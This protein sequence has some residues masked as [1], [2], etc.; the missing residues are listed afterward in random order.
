MVNW[1]SPEEAETWWAE[2]QE[3][4]KKVSSIEERLVSI[5]RDVHRSI[6]LTFLRTE[7]RKYIKDRLF[8]Y[9]DRLSK[10]KSEEE[11]SNNLHEFFEEYGTYTKSSR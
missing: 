7:T 9:S 11:M 10:C 4:K 2:L 3:L 6:F 5:A 1:K 8:Y